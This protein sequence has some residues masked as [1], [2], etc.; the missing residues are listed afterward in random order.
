MIK[1]FTSRY[2]GR[3][4]EN[5]LKAQKQGY[6]MTTEQLKNGKLAIIN[7]FSAKPSF[8]LF[9]DDNQFISKKDGTKIL[10]IFLIIYEKQT[11]KQIF[12]WCRVNFK[13][14]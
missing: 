4:K 6:R 5:K 10:K 9:I 7:S 1:L 8:D 12:L 2:M 3:N 14:N 11:Y 13:T